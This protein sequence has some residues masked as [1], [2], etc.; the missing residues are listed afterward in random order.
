M[1]QFHTQAEAEPAWPSQ[2]SLQ[3]AGPGLIS[4]EAQRSPVLPPGG[5]FAVDLEGIGWFFL[6]VV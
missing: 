2:Q 5:G 4:T 3:G 1:S 6:N